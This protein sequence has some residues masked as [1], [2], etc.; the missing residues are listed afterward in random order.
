[1]YYLLSHDLAVLPTQLFSA[2]TEI[3]EMA[4]RNPFGADT[5]DYGTVSGQSSGF[6]G[7]GGGGDGSE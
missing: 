2:N 4:N 1:M 3:T 6:G 5:A 7:G